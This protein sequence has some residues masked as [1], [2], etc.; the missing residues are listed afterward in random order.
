MTKVTCFED[1]KCW[2]AARVLVKDIYLISESG[3]LSK[4]FDTKSQF[5]RAALSVII[6]YMRSKV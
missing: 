1:L 5:N 3:K 4:D 2:Q 6:R